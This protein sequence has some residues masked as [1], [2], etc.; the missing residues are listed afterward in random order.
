MKT[1]SVLECGGKARRAGIFVET[2]TRNDSSSVGAA[3]SVEQTEYAA[4]PGLKCLWPVVL[5]RFRTY[6]AGAGRAILVALGFILLHSAFSLSVFGQSYLIDWYKIAGG[7]GTSTGGTYQVTGTIGQPDAS[8]QTMSGGAYTLNGGFWSII[9]AIQTAGLPNLTI[10][11]LSPNSVQVL[12]PATGTYTL[13][14]NNNL[15]TA[16]WTAY[17]GSISNSN[18]TNSII[19]TPPS[20]N[21]FFRLKQ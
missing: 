20:G 19:V 13:Q 7:G 2:G 14:T 1:R 15:A 11:Y 8:L 4:P 6:G 12:W 3:S 17:G 18:G 21:L 5:Q 9:A 10:N 16:N